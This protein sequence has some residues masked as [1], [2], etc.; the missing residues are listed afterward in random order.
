M[1]RQ[2]SPRHDEKAMAQSK[3]TPGGQGSSGT[4]SGAGRVERRGPPHR[5]L[6]VLPRRLTGN[7]LRHLL[8]GYELAAAETWT[9]ALR[10][11]RHNAYDLYVVYAPLGWAEP[12]EICR[13]IREFDAHTPVILYS[14]QPSAAERREA[15]A[16]R[17]IQAY[18][19]RSDDAHNLAGTAGQL[20]MLAELR[21][22]EA[23][24]LGVEAMQAHIA[25]RLARAVAGADAAD[26]PAHA[27]ARA[28][29]DRGLP[30]LRRGRRQPR[31]F[32]AAVALDS[33]K[34][35]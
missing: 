15:L 11:A 4:A 17:A 35:R 19:A 20:I 18:V 34:T 30:D 3:K 33:T 12:A 5:I 2:E 10:L 16:Q 6:C 31:Q 29:E 32:R 25:R 22:M 7:P 27:H 13:R 8:Q 24:R 23:M 9:A 1:H 21:S 14:A 28:A 26:A